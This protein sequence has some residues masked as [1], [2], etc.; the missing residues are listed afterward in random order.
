MSNNTVLNSGSGGDTIRDIDR[1]G[2]KT[3]VTLI[4][5]GGAGSE[6]IWT[7]AALADATSNPT[8]VSLATFLF[9]FNGTTWD[10]LQVDGSKFLKVNVAAGTVSIT[11]N[12]SVNVAQLAGTAT[13][14]NSGNKDAGTLRVVIATDQPQLTSA[15][16]VDGSAVTQPVSGTVT[17]NQGG[18]NWS[19]NVAQVAGGNTSNA[20]QTGALQVGG[21]VATNNNVSSACYPILIAGSDY[22]GTPKIQS[23]KVD[24]SGNGQV[25][26]TN[27]P[28]VTIQSNAAVNVAQ[29]GGNAVAT[30]TGAGGNGIPRVTVSN[31]SAVKLWDGTTTTSVDT[32]GGIKNTPVPTSN[33]TGPTTSRI[34]SAASTNATNLKASAGQVYGWYLYNNTGSAKFFKWFNKA[35]T[36]TAGTD[37][38]L[39]T[40]GI[41]ANGGCVHEFKMGIPFGT[42]IGYTITGSVADS[43]TTNTAADDVHGV[44]LWK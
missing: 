39:F 11:A 17:A 8:T 32:V 41:P 33:Q 37:T 30:G 13:S 36:P 19:V 21:A 23:W 44:V 1:S 4:D 25:A 9:G 35:S 42:G 38:P 15:L 40:V 28:N 26:V 20:G 22:G 2:V 18:S 43:D 6:S 24:G 7:A 14:V 34:K 3:P 27:T 10:R 16:K 5:I 29:F 12:S 31:D